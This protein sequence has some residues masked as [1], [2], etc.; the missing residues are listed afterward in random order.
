MLVAIFLSH[1]MYDAV[2]VLRR[3]P[4]SYDVSAW[5]DSQHLGAMVWP[6]LCP[7]HQGVRGNNAI[8]HCKS[9]HP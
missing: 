5:V 4:E 6:Y 8:K 3:V 2:A 7:C 1:S 9:V